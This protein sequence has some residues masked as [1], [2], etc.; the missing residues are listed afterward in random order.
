[1]K[2]HV[3][4]SEEEQL[5][6]L[7]AEFDDFLATGRSAESA[8]G[9]TSMEAPAGL[10]QG[11]AWCRLVRRL[12]AVPTKNVEE[13]APVA[14]PLPVNLGRFQIRRELGRGGCGVVFL[15]YDPKLEREVALKVPRPEVILYPDLRA[16]FAQE[17]RAA[18]SLDHP[19]LV[20]VYEAGEEGEIC[21]IA[22]AFCPGTTLNDWL[23]KQTEPLAFD[24]AARLLA[25]LAEALEH[26]HRRGI[27]HRD[28]KPANIMLSPRQAIG[29]SM[30]AHDAQGVH[31]KQTL[32]FVPR[33]MDFGLAKLLEGEP[34]ITAL[35]YQ[36]QSGAIVGTPNYMAP[37]QASGQNNGASPATDVYAL[38]GILYELLTGQPPFRAEN[39][40][41]TLML[42]QTQEPLPPARLRFGVPRDLETICL[43]CL[44]KDPGRRYV[45]ARALADDLQRF[46]SRQPILGRRVGPW[47]R[48]ALWCRRNQVL[49]ATIAVALVAIATVA[50]TGIYQ[51]FQERDRYRQERDLA[52]ANL[53][54]ALTG[55][56]RSLMQSRDTGWWWKAMDNIRQAAALEVAE[57]D[58]RELRELAIECMG[59][60][61]PC[62]RLH[63]TWKG[64]GGPINSVAFSADG[65]LAVSTSDDQTAR[66]WSVPSGQP[67]AVLTGH[68]QPVTNALFL[69][70]GKWIASSSADGSVRGWCLDPV[71]SNEK[72]IAPVVLSAAQVFDLNANG[73]NAMEMSTDGTWLAA[74]CQDGTIRM[75]SVKDGKLTDQTGPRTLTGHAGPVTCL[76][77]SASGQL[78]SGGRD[79]S[80]R[81]WDL[82]TLQQTK[83]WTLTNA[84]NAL[85]FD[86]RGPVLF[87]S[88]P[89][90]FGICTGNLDTNDITP[91]PH[92][93]SAAVSQ[94]RLTRKDG[95]LTASA[96]GTL[97]VW[98]GQIRGF[99]EAAVA[100][101]EWGEARAVAFEAGQH[102]IAAGYTDGKVR[103]WEFSKPP[104]RTL[105][106]QDSQSAAFVGDQRHLAVHGRILDFS[107]GS[108]GATHG[109]LPEEVHALA[110]QPNGRRFAF[111]DKAGALTIGE[112]KR[113]TETILCAGHAKKI[114]CLASSADS[115]YL[116][117]ASE[118][119]TVKVWSWETG[120]CQHILEPGLGAVHALAWGKDNRH[121]AMIGAGGMSIGDLEAEG[122]CRRMR[123]HS[124]TTTGIAVF[125]DL[126]AF[127]GPDNTIEICEFPSCNHKR[128]LR[129]HT[130]PV[131]ALEFSP[132]GNLLASGAPDGTVRL[133]ET[134]NGAPSTVFKKA[135]AYQIVAWWLAFD[136][137]GRYLASCSTG[138]TQLWDLHSKTPAAYFF[139]RCRC[140]RFSP[141]GSAFLAGDDVGSVRLCTRE[142]IEK[143]RQAAQGPAKVFPS[144][145]VLVTADAVLVQGGH[146]SAVWAIAASPDGRWVATASHDHTVK[147]WDAS[148]R[149]LV[150]TLEGHQGPVWCLAFS[151]DSRYL[152]SGSE[153][154]GAGDVQVWE[155]ATG[156]EYCHFRAHQQI[157]RALAFHPTEPL[158]VSC[159]MDGSVSLWDYA[160][161]KELGVLHQFDQEVY[162]LAFRPDGRCLAAACQDKR[163]AIWD[164]P[165]ATVPA[166]PS[167]FLEGHTA[168]VWA[169]AFSSDGKYLASG[170]D[171]GVTILWD[172]RTFSRV[173]TLR[174]GTGQ[175]RSLSF[176][177]DSQLLAG[178][179]YVRPTIV[180]DLQSV[181]ATLKVLK[182][183]W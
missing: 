178:G 163:I 162:N 39:V 85:T 109:M 78:V 182:L 83:C 180:W 92:L 143:A 79:K 171:R 67:L 161:A 152:A 68:G 58:P 29:D 77:F 155:V 70:G 166:L 139:G 18:A 172:G 140:G 97:K 60:E 137:Q 118:D 95:L 100:R 119:G 96:D 150:R 37:E 131:S 48:T 16:R 41:S 90:I 164:W 136:P 51:V 156:L 66:V 91:I 117:S 84:P 121:L 122:E 181:R 115:D 19:N 57:R 177:R 144:T 14:A 31:G 56:A 130:A 36:T 3:A 105:V 22:S 102:W 112:M 113:P 142:S 147:L 25:T 151:P 160:A 159:S 123:V 120:L 49:A 125:G 33:I 87:W 46:L 32:D 114:H 38:G 54:R 21:Y 129:G 47:G 40:V 1:M 127:S 175:I 55:E 170:S 133:W 10:E 179:A 44:H 4:Q 24:Q 73:V 132:A 7:L 2:P 93:H 59:S 173:T 26:A 157:V 98:Q 124:L 99:R 71:Y 81:F 110:L 167:R 145:P 153:E 183:D 165:A 13:A 134:A 64:H 20:P 138:D 107:Q 111:A 27:L 34:G 106:P 43:K 62:L 6:V 88:E 45:S 108:D 141:D 158:L 76:A 126:I 101:G 12:L 5:A 169:L 103:L 15:A 149:K 94:I 52:Q 168:G 9:T 80:I 50:G 35:G 128:T 75:M 74:A 69:P 53:Y 104:Q 89:E 11:I 42:V 30:T 72:P 23:K 65:R 135:T 116:A 148:A 8:N 17:A 28:L 61:F 82:A 63:D 174:G 154:T 176:S 146:T 86:E